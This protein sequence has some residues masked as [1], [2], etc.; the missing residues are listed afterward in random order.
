LGDELVSAAA[1][2][3]S[4]SAASATTAIIDGITVTDYGSVNPAGPNFAQPGFATGTAQIQIGEVNGPG[5]P[6]Q[7]ANP[8][9][10]PYRTSDTTHSW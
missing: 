7:F 5:N 8:G 6:P 2:I 4:A 9:R 10:N 1:A 3:L